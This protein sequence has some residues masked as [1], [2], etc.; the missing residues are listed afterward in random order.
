MD[1]P[2]GA[3]SVTVISKQLDDLSFGSY[4]CSKERQALISTLT[5]DSFFHATPSVKFTGTFLM[6][7]FMHG[8]IFM[9]F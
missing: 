9:A 6:P 3:L 2:E 7:Y 1:E 5:K 4:F 8:L